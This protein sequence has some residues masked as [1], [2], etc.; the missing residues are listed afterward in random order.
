MLLHSD[1]PHDQQSA[2]TTMSGEIQDAKAKLAGVV[3]AVKKVASLRHA[4]IVPVIDA[5]EHDGAYYVVTEHEGAMSLA[6]RIRVK[7]TIPDKEAFDTAAQVASA[8][9][10]A[11]H[12]KGL[13]HGNLKPD[14]IL[15]RPDHAVVVSNLGLTQTGQLADPDTGEIREVL[16]GTPNYMAPEQA[17][18]E[19]HIDCR[20]DMY[21]LGA[22][23]YHMVTGTIPFSDAQGEAAM[24]K[25]IH[26]QLPNPRELRSEISPRITAF[27]TRLLMKSPADR[28]ESWDAV[29]EEIKRIKA[30]KV[31]VYKEGSAGLSTVKA[32]SETIAGASAKGKGKKSSELRRVVILLKWAAVWAIWALVAYEVFR[33]S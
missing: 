22:T 6:E 16:L 27:I 11:W 4:G 12:E 30:T 8:L 3:D 21:S 7:G 5:G 2:E 20:A 14:T 10:C 23:L 13:M 17:R 25:H 33:L 29:R 15:I 28:F 26:D 32:A 9:G 24:Y 1:H 19:A 18:G 31:F